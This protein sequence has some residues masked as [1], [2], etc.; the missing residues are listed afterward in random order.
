MPWNVQVVGS[1]TTTLANI[2]Q[3]AHPVS[4]QTC[5]PSPGGI[6]SVGPRPDLLHLDPSLPH[7]DALVAASGRSLCRR[8]QFLVRDVLR[9]WCRHVSISLCSFPI[10]AAL[11]APAEVRNRTDKIGTHLVLSYAAC[12]TLPGFMFCRSG[13]AT[14][15]GRRCWMLTTTGQIRIGWLKCLLRSSRC[16]TGTTMMPD[17]FGGA[18]RSQLSRSRTVV[19]QAGTSNMRSTATTLQV[20]MRGSL[21]PLV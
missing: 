15:L 6:Q 19:E 10:S 11:R 16:G 14:E 5:R 8:R 13:E 17:G 21:V 3:L 20:S 7:C 4:T 12:T 18:R 1:N 9:R 2:T